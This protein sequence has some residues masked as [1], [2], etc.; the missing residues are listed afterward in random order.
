MKHSIE[1]EGSSW[2]EGLTVEIAMKSGAPDDI[3]DRSVECQEQQHEHDHQVSSGL[4]EPGWCELVQ[5]HQ[6]ACLP[7]QEFE[8]E[9]AMTTCRDQVLKEVKDH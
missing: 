7:R 1:E 2:Q 6:Q 8:E 9:S 3:P 5:D 4:E